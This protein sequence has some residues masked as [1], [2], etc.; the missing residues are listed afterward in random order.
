MESLSLQV[1]GRVLVATLPSPR[2]FGGA[3]S[4]LSNLLRKVPPMVERHPQLSLL[5]LRSGSPGAP[6][7]GRGDD[8]LVAEAGLL[9]RWEKL[10]GNF[11]ELKLGLVACVEAPFHMV[12]TSCMFTRPRRPI[13]PEPFAGTRRSRGNERGA[14]AG[15]QLGMAILLACDFRLASPSASFVA[16]YAHRSACALHVPPDICSLHVAG[17]HTGHHAGHQQTDERRTSV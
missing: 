5:V 17:H 16:M 12:S 9:P 11:R 14:L 7:F 15:V 8:L 13:H 10:V 1:E 6:L 4:L 2:A 3:V